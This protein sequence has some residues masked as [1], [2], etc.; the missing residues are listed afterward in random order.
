[1]RNEFQANEA[2]EWKE[3]YPPTKSQK[4]TTSKSLGRSHMRDFPEKSYR[5]VDSWLLPLRAAIL[6]NWIP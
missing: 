1:M 6:M 4:R 5:C 3:I 2:A